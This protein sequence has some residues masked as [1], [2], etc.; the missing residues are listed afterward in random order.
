MTE[1]PSER[2]WRATFGSG[3]PYPGQPRAE[4]GRGSDRARDAFADSL[5]R[6]GFRVESEADRRAREE[7]TRR[8]RASSPR[9]S[10]EEAT[11]AAREYLRRVVPERLC[12]C[13]VWLRCP[14]HP[15]AGPLRV[16]A[17]RPRPEELHR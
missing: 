7:A 10:R 6:G 13:A 9:Q 16:V 5:R 11:A 1:T 15:D 3:V 2:A 17:V 4:P 8:F 14:I 12:V